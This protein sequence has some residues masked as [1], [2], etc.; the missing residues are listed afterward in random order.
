[1]D[2]HKTFTICGDPLYFAPEIVTQ[3]G[4]DHGAD[5]WALGVLYCELFEGNNP[6]GSHDSEETAIFKKLATFNPDAL[7]FTKKTPKKAKSIISSLLDPDVSK[8]L[9]YGGPEDVQGKKFFSDVDWSTIGRDKTITID[10]MGRVDAI[11]PEDFAPVV[12]PSS[13]DNW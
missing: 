10:M 13:F 3:R 9:G 11:D 5:L 4:Y 6:I 7:D 12:K 2:G 1:M 8:R